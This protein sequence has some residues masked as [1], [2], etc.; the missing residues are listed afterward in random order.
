MKKQSSIE[1][2]FDELKRLNV[3][4]P[5]ESAIELLES[6]KKTKDMHKQEIV[7]AWDSAEANCIHRV[8]QERTDC[9]RYG[10]EYYKNTYEKEQN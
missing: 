6:Y 1:W 5:S 7:E 2:F 4:V 3:T 8:I 10:D 9:L